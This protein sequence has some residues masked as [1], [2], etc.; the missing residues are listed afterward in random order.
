MTSGKVEIG[1]VARELGIAPSTLRTWERRYNLV[2]PQRGPNGERL[3]D[4]EQIV[5][6]RRV[7]A[8]IRRG[9]RASHAHTA[10]LAVHPRRTARLRL[11]PDPQAPQLARAAVDELV[12]DCGHERFAFYLRLVASELVK[13][14]VLYG[15]SREPIRLEMSL[16]PNAAELRVQNAGSR[17]RV[18]SLRTQRP[19]GGR[20]LEIVDA[21]AESLTID[22][23]PLGTRVSV[24]LPMEPA[25]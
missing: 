24:R 10:A 15:S 14:A 21:L 20:G 17:L 1:A 5:L 16:Y 3:Y 23:G 6:L 8:Q 18:K 7:L 12:A 25:A 19:D 4:S 22:T 9:V 13:N 2:V 11:D